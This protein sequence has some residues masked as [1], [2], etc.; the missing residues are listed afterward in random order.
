MPELLS[1]A[2]LTIALARYGGKIEAHS[3]MEAYLRT[4]RSSEK[5]SIGLKTLALVDANMG[6]VKL[7]IV[8]NN[9]SR[10]VCCG[11]S[12]L[13]IKPGPIRRIS[14]CYKLSFAGRLSPVFRELSVSTRSLLLPLLLLA[15]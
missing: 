5:I 10:G 13:V 15:G 2:C 3:A 9:I 8:A 4:Y 6:E 14:L 7:Y 11:V 12:W 1:K